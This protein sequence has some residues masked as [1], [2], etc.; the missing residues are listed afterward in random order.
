MDIVGTFS[1]VSIGYGADAVFVAPVSIEVAKLSFDVERILSEASQ[2][3]SVEGEHIEQSVLLLAEELEAPRINT[4]PICRQPATMKVSWPGASSY[5][6]SD[7][8]LTEV[9]TNG[10]HVDD[11]WRRLT[12]IFA[13]ISLSWKRTTSQIQRCDRSSASNERYGDS[14]T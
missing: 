10:P 8:V 13:I 4:R 5:P 3:R 14:R 12:K 7:F 11:A 9:E 6:W 1:E 2:R